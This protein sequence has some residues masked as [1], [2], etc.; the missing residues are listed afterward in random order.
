MELAEALDQAIAGVTRSLGRH[1]KDKGNLGAFHPVADNGGEKDTHTTDDSF[2]IF[3][4]A[5]FFS[6]RKKKKKKKVLIFQVE[7]NNKH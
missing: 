6:W 2:R 1:L 7:N 4:P 3:A 5:S